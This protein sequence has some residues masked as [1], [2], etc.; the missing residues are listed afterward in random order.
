MKDQ[1]VSKASELFFKKGYKMTS[2]QEVA[3]S[4]DIKASSLYYYF[5]G[6]KEE[7]YVE[8]LRVRLNEYRQQVTRLSQNFPALDVFLAEFAKWFVL[9]PP[10]NMD[11][12]SQ[13][14]MPF[15]SIKGR[16]TAMR[17]VR[18]SIFGP[19]NQVLSDHSPK[20]KNIDTVRIVGIYITLLNGLNSAVRGGYVSFDKVVEDFVEVF[21]RGVLR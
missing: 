16:E 10:M 6:G 12:I 14:D 9:Q 4:L 2:L 15:L 8:V 13:F 17:L 11:L 20:F 1:V 5:P 3:D 18:E 21:L 7:L 19:L